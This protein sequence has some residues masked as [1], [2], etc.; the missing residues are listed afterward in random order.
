MNPF[1][2]IDINDIQASTFSVSAK[3]GNQINQ[4]EVGESVKIDLCGLSQRSAR[5][6]LSNKTRKMTKKF[7]TKMPKGE[8]WVMRV[9]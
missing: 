1:D 7:I 2:K 4:L 5:G 3:I 8:L 9:S 6:C